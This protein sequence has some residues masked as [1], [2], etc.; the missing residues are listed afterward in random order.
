MT[1]VIRLHEIPP[2]PNNTKIRVAL[3][4]KKLA[5]ER[6][7]LNIDQY[8]GDRTEIIKVSRQPLTPVLIHGDHVM[9][10]SASILRYLEANFP[11][12]LPLFSG[13]WET[14]RA[15]EEWERMGRYKFSD[16]VSI[17]F[18]QASRPEKDPDACRGASELMHDLSGPVESQLA[19][20]PYLITDRLTAADI[21]VAAYVFLSIL[22]AKA[23]EAS[24]IVRF[25]RENLTLGDD[26]KRTREWV[27]KV[28]AHDEDLAG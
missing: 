6:I 9:F 13:D 2:S 24:P 19:Q 22:P 12:T 27:M 3:G 20:T 7:P 1:P 16:P 21:T 4:Y 5:Y 8:P 11:D 26:R 23:A 17:I 25:F 15:I 14:M 28:M 18:D 10:D